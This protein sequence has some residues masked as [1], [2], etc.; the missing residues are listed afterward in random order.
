MGFMGP[1]N[2]FPGGTTVREMVPSQPN[3]AEIARKAEELRQQELAAAEEA[4]KKE[5]AELL[6]RKGRRQT[7]LTGSQGVTETAPVSKKTLLGE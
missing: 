2:P 3:E 5:K 4:K 7:I 6:K 1:L